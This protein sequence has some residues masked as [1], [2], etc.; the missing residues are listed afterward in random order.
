MERA[1]Q[2]LT[3]AI[4]GFTRAH[5]ALIIGRGQPAVDAVRA[6]L[7][8]VIA[9]ASNSANVSTY[10]NLNDA[11][12]K[13]AAA[14]A[15]AGGGG[16]QARYV[17]DALQGADPAGNVVATKAS[18]TLLRTLITGL[19]RGATFDMAA[20]EI[21]ASAGAIAN[22]L[23]QQVE[24]LPQERLADRRHQ[25]I[26]YLK[27]PDAG[28]PETSVK[29]LNVG[30]FEIKAR[31]ECIGR[32]RFDTRLVRN[33]FFITNV[34]RLVRL[35]LNRELTQSRSVLT[36]AHTAVAPGLTEYGTDPFGPNE[37]YGSTLPNGY[38]RYDD[39]DQLP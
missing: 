26:A 19:P 36:S 20:H 17:L 15:A 4:A 5:N 29:E 21:T 22:P 32:M 12:A 33:L 35:K 6:A 2:V 39:R 7:D 3:E 38:D 27:L 13:A 37:V 24:W 14:V 31:L 28:H 34:L 23:A 1:S 25:N 16:T 11:L 30:S 10:S 8:V 9:A 18:A